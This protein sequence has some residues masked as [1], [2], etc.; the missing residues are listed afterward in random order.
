VLWY[1]VNCCH[2]SNVSIMAVL[3]SVA[4]C[5]TYLL[6]ICRWPVLYLAFLATTRDL[7]SGLSG[8]CSHGDLLTYC[9]THN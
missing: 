4:S 3:G 5:P 6:Q 2:V 7:C 8:L 1:D 9:A